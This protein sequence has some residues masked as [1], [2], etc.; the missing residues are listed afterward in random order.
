MVSHKSS[1]AFSQ[2]WVQSSSAATSAKATIAPLFWGLPF[3][4]L[5]QCK[6]TDEN[7]NVLVH[8]L[9]FY[10][11]PL[12]MTVN[13]A[14]LCDGTEGKIFSLGDTMKLFLPH[15]V[16]MVF[17]RAAC[18]RELGGSIKVKNFAFK[19]VAWLKKWVWERFTASQRYDCSHPVW[20]LS[21]VSYQLLFG[22][23]HNSVQGVR[24][25]DWSPGWRVLSVWKLLRNQGG[26]WESAGM[27]LS[28]LMQSKHGVCRE[29]CLGYLV[30]PGDTRTCCRS[31][32]WTQ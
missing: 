7:S 11:V 15:V 17:L 8:C 10:S 30:R 3:L 19:D 16:A 14:Q 23:R 21:S 13:A 24:V 27:G 29:E 26:E 1:V 4:T 5:F 9:W 32:R 2:E 31:H 6:F 25:R 28:I 18:C 12:L 20:I 22:N